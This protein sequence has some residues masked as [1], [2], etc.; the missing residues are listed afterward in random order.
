MSLPEVV[1]VPRFGVSR[2]RSDLFFFFAR[3]NEGPTP[4]IFGD[5]VTILQYVRLYSRTVMIILFGYGIRNYFS[6]PVAV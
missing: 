5:H 1:K 2:R 6:Y 3:R 4:R